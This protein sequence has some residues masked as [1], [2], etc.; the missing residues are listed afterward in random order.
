MARGSRIFAAV[1]ASALLAGCV[2]VNESYTGV[3][4]TSKREFL[5]YAGGESP[6]LVTVVNAPFSQGATAMAEMAA[7]LA[8]VSIS[9][10]TVKFTADPALANQPHFRVVMVFDPPVTA[11]VHDMCQADTSAPK[12]A[13]SGGDMRIYS[14]FCAREEPLSGTE[15]RGPAPR[16]MMD[17]NTEKMVRMAFENMFPLNDSDGPSEEPIR[18]VSAPVPSSGS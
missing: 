18:I 16:S 6:V 9:E 5:N 14:V 8:E 4:N 15:V 2:T 1:A 12:V 11:S 3:N 13:R 17:A 7:R 10:S